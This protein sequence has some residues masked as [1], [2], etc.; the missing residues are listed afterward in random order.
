[1]PVLN[2]GKWIA[3]VQP[4]AISLTTGRRLWDDEES[5]IL[6]RMINELSRDYL[7]GVIDMDRRIKLAR[8]LLDVTRKRRESKVTNNGKT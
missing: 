6:L 3:D 8:R 2:Q 7:D 5:Q 1:M 4:D